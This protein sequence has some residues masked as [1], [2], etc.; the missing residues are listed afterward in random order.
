M[1]IPI[2]I[3]PHPDDSDD[4]E[5]QK[6]ASCAEIGGDFWHP[7]KGGSIAEAVSICQGC[8]V[9]VECLTFAL[10]HHATVGRFGVW[11]GTSERERR[12]MKRK[13]NAA[14]AEEAAA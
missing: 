12:R 11:G 13:Q 10:R 7:D 2:Y 6:D 4:L 3:S 8:R 5:W 9:R 14:I 1:S